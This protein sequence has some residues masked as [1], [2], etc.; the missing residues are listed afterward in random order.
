MSILEEWLAEEPGDPIALHM[1][2]ACTGRD[3]PRARRTRSSR[4][5]STASP[6]ASSRSSRSCRTARRRSWRRCWRSRASSRRSASTC[7]TPAAER[8]CAARSWHPM[9]ADWSASIS[10]GHAGA[11]EGE[12]RLRRVVE[13][14][15]DRVPA[16]PSRG[17][18]PDRVG[19]HARVFRRPRRRPRRRRRSAAPE[20]APRVHARARLDG[21]EATGYRLELHGRYSH[22]RAYVERLLASLGPAGRDRPR[23]VAHGVGCAG[24]RAGGSGDEAGRATQERGG[25][26]RPPSGLAGTTGRPVPVQPP[27]P[28]HV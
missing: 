11:R 21:D 4:G 2:A 13:G 27:R 3:V 26:G 23:R 9:R 1:L 7:S 15:V 17:L 18:R 5:R 20:R 25:R 14:R 10:P 12:A 8:G 22:T 19:R 16:R 24:G 28:S 6:P